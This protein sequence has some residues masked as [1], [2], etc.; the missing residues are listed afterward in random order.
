MRAKSFWI[1]VLCVVLLAACG[2]DSDPGP[3]ADA[4]PPVDTAD[5]V[6]DAVPDAAPDAVPARAGLTRKAPVWA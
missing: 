3:T 5:V 6:G 4:A 2:D 1:V